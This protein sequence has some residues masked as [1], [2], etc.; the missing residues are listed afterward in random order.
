MRLQHEVSYKDAKV[1]VLYHVGNGKSLKCTE[2]GLGVEEDS[3]S[4][5][6]VLTQ[7]RNDSHLTKRVAIEMEEN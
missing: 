7:V 5:I 4:K 2:N 6:I 1:S 3:G